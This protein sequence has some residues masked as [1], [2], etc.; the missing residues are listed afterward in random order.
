M[1]RIIGGRTYNTETAKLITEYSHG[2]P[3]DEGYYCE[4][5]YSTARKAFFLA[6]EGGAR[7]HYA[8]EFRDWRYRASDDIIRLTDEEVFRWL[9]DH[10]RT[11]EIEDLFGE[12]PEAGDGTVMLCL[13]VTEEV[14][15]RAA[16][17][18][19]RSGT[20]IQSWLSVL[21]EK[22]APPNSSE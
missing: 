19:A 2:Y 12:Q 22:A 15:R 7:S 5:L 14:E 6:C 20:N 4:R 16:R 10:E 1:K 18:A 3:G 9:E 21:L 17:A 11:S 13:R 8:Y